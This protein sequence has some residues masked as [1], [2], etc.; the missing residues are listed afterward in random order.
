MCRARKQIHS[1]SPPGL[2]APLL[3]QLHIPPQCGRVAGYIHDSLRPHPHHGIN[4]FRCQALAGW[5]YADHV[6]TQIIR[7]QLDRDVGGVAAEEFHI[8]NAVCPGVLPGVLHRRGHDLCADEFLCPVRHGQGDGAGP[9]VQIQHQ[10]RSGKPGV[11]HRPAVQHLRLL[12]VHLVKG[13]DGQ[14]K[15]V[16]A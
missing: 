7:R 2:V 9:A 6:R 1:R 5:V 11:V 14:P 8:G 16:A 3:Q 12:P 13:G 4:N 15:L 10:L